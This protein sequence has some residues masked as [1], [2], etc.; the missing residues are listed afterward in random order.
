M[1]DLGPTCE[2]DGRPRLVILRRRLDLIR[3]IFRVI[4]IVVLVVMIIRYLRGVFGSKRPSARAIPPPLPPSG[5]RAAPFAPRAEVKKLDL[6]VTTFAPLSDSQIQAAAAGVGNLWGNPFFGRR[7]LIPPADDPRTNLIDRGMVAH[8]LITPEELTDIHRLGAEMDKVRPD[9]SLAS[10]AAAQVVSDDRAAR[11]RIREQK[12]QESAE[13]KRLT[14]EAIAQRRANDI[15]Y[16]GRGVSKGL[17][18]R[19]GNVEKLTAKGLP[20]LATPLELASVLGLT[21]PRL[22]WLAF[23]SEAATVIHYIPFT[24]PKKGGGTR[25]LAAPHES[26][27][28]AQEWILSNILAK[29][30]LHASAHGFVPGRSTVTNATGHVGKGVVLNADL[31]DFFPSITVWR[32]EGVFHELGYSPSV[33]AI[34]ALLCTEAPRRRIEYEGKPFFVATGPRALPQG[35]C[36]SPALSNL[37]ARR[38]DS[39]LHGIA[40]KLGWTYSRYADDLTFSSGADANQQVG[41]LLA[42]IRHLCDDEGFAINGKK[43]RVLRRNTAQSVTGIIVNDQPSVGRHLT[44]RIRA[45]LHRAKTQGLAAQNRQNHPHFV[46][47]LRGMIAY[48]H[49]V[50][51]AQARALRAA[52][53]QLP[54]S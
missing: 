32:V 51:P 22:R 17:A 13:R 16:L 9:M 50:N 30:P 21:I 15:I 46:A 23:H 42:R 44:R 28:N 47:W 19:R 26:L 41:Y 54:D 10:H 31:K 38:L 25:Q 5:S 52:L 37:V 48:I 33:S 29:V 49:M 1:N 11:Q 34:L 45:I 27:A 40:A 35:A 6:D 8:G 7:D 20:L 3:Y 12:K 39:R 4:I 36:T 14:A 18:D 53:E 2:V 43:T 24:I